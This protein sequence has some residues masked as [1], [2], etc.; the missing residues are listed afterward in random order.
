MV[1]AAATDAWEF[2]RFLKCGISSDTAVAAL[3]GLVHVTP[4]PLGES[5]H[6][7]GTNL[8]DRVDH[9]NGSPIWHAGA[10]PLAAPPP[11]QPLSPAS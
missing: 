1:A 9:H 11:S 4:A 5:I 2:S 7:A 8:H 3:L 10:G 6:T